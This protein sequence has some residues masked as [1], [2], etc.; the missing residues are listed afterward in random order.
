VEKDVRF[1]LLRQQKN[2]GESVARNAALKQ[3]RGE[4][5]AFL[6]ADDVWLPGKLAAQL[7]LLRREPNANLLFTDYF[8]WDGQ[9]DF[10]RRYSDPDKFPDGDVSRR[11]IFFDLFGISTV[12]IKREI[13]DV[14]GLFDVE[15][16]LAQ[17]WDLWLRIAERGLCAKGVRQPMVRYRSGRAVSVATR[18]GCAR[19]TFLCWRRRWQDRKAHLDD[20]LTNVLCKSPVAT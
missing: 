3:A 8:L 17:D 15:M 10:G 12:M 14:V 9:N 20:A 6:D 19:A 4:W 2:I 5:I 16:S 11:L 1:I 13:L 18:S 7:D